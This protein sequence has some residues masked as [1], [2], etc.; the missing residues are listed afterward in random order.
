MPKTR[1][2]LPAALAIEELEACFVGCDHNGQELAD[3]YF[4]D[5]SGWRSAIKLL[6]RDEARRIASNIAKLPE[7]LRNIKRPRRKPRGRVT[8]N[9]RSTFVSAFSSLTTAH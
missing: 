7:L 5:E 8:T 9:K 1:V 3:V 6:T 2:P 4:E